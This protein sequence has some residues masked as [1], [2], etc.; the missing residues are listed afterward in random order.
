MKAFPDEEPTP[1]R[2]NPK[3][4]ANA[5]FDR[6]FLSFSMALT[7]IQRSSVGACL[8]E[9]AQEE[10]YPSVL[11]LLGLHGVQALHQA[12]DALL[13]A[14]DGVVLRVMATETV[15]QAAERVADELQVAGLQAER[16]CC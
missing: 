10:H 12:G 14:V 9:T 6:V 11:F 4:K 5:T 3:R 15:A 8:Q 7:L 16:T 1:L 2:G 13:Q